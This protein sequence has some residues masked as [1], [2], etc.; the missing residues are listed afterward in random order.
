M[1]ARET[2]IATGLHELG[3]RASDEA[4]LRLESYARLLAARGISEGFLGPNERDRIVP[5]HIL[6]AC[7]LARHLPAEGTVIDVGAG[8]GL[9]GIPLACLERWDVTLADSNERRATFLRD[10]VDA[11]DLSTEIVVGRAEE[12][13]RSSLRDSF[14]AA[15]SRA[16]AAPP[17]ALELCLPF[18]AVGGVYASLVTPPQ[19]RAAYDAPPDVA[20]DRDVQPRVTAP[21]HGGAQ[22]DAMVGGGGG[23]VS[24]MAAVATRLGGDDP[25]LR[26][27]EVPG[28][29]APRWVMIVNKLEAT[30]DRFPRRTGVP[31]RR[32]LC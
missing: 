12:L 31:S 26:P 4:V 7:A 14:A 20:A 30:P 19:A 8:A 9:P 16:L 15:V 10:V 22:V 17:V 2:S 21:G 29:D 13:G 5:R 23:G 1:V 18:V 27:L 3:I 6:E 28:V 32:P 25:V 24:R 11:L